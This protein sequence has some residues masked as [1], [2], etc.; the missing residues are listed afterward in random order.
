[1]VNSS[2]THEAIFAN[3]ASEI[4]GR[5]DKQYNNVE[6]Y[7]KLKAENAK[8]VEENARLHN[9]LIS[10][11]DTPDT[12]KQQKID[13]VYIDSTNKIRRFTWLPAKVVNNSIT[14]ENNYITL[15][16]GSNQGVKKDMAVVGESG[17]V[18][19]VI[20]VNNNYSR[21]MSL[22]NR[23]T[24]VSGMLKKNRYQGIVDW[25]GKS[26]TELIFHGIPKSV[27]IK[28]GDS[29]VT[30][31]LSGNFPE[32]LLIGTVR[33]I[34]KDNSTNFYT[35]KIRTAENFYAL[36]HVYLVENLL[37]AEQKQL[38]AQTPKQQ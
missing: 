16:R 34:V 10:N 3:V 22:L 21:V 28:K 1:M 24:K 36:Q 29:V 2:K 8:L 35:L 7:F 23:F 4:T 27:E 26:P 31:N 15:Y 17:I 11:F 25:D 32:G 5:V 13:S 18:G 38:E 30:S 33:S 37:L 12:T 9:L 19:R 14:E 6:Y 20:I